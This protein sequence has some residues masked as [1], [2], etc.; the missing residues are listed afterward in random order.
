MYDFSAIS[1]F[2]GG[3]YWP[4]DGQLINDLRR[5]WAMLP[6]RRTSLLDACCTWFIERPDLQQVLREVGAVW[7]KISESLSGENQ[8]ALLRW[9]A[10]FD[11]SNW[12]KTIHN[13]QEV[14]QR[15]L[16]EELR[17]VEAERA[18]I[19]RQAALALPYQCSDLLEKRL[20]IEASAIDGIW[21]QL[22]NWP[23][24]AAKSSNP[25]QDELSSSLLDDRHSR[26]GL[27][28]VL[29]SLG[30]EWLDQDQA[31]RP[32]IEEEVRKLVADPPKI[33]A[34]SPDDTHEDG[35]GFL[36]RCAV[37]CWARYPD[38]ADWR[39]L[40]GSF[41]TAYR[42]RTIAQVFDEAFRVRKS[43]G[44][45]YG[46]LEA[47]ALEYAVVRRKADLHGFK[48]KPEMIH[49]W[50]Q[51]WLPKFAKGHG[52][53][54]TNEWSTVEFVE[55][56]PPP[57]NPHRGLTDGRTQR[58]SRRDYG[59]DMGV[60]L[61]AFG[62]LPP[63][64]DSR[65]AQERQHWLAIDNEI[66]AAYA[67][68]FPTDDHDDEE[69]EWEFQHWSADEKIYN[70][71][72]ARLFE[73]STTEQRE[74]WLPFLSLPPPAHHYITQ[75]LSVVLIET[76]RGASP[77]IAE[78]LP[79]WRAFAQHLFSLPRWTGRLRHRQEEVWK[80]IFFYG[81]PFDSVR[82]KDHAPLVKGMRDLFERHVRAMGSNSHEQSSL[83]GFVT[84]DAGK[85]L[86]P[87]ALEWLGPSWQHASS[88]FWSDVAESSSFENLLRY[89]WQNHFAEIRANAEMLKAFKTVT[90]NLAAHQVAVAIDIQ[91]QIGA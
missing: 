27:L 52:P 22:H 74:L 60:I 86:L 33:T 66:L 14:W 41:V 26:A 54:W 57:Y 46:E 48:A 72:A 71:I 25:D 34:Y 9:A 70:L 35:E 6:G 15:E 47:F 61:A 43:L 87:E 89:A 32:W 30:S 5:D 7:K 1:E 10:N 29:L 37:C 88:Y 77:R 75:F 73:C 67:R 40:V 58:F 23:F 36:A 79:I 59:L 56:F 18:H 4:Q 63:L 85:G 65:D 55:A 69:D 53:K 62:W 64:A 19:H 42:Y 90:L 24:T 2:L 80:Y 84:S 76:L 81:T 17:D 82:D 78:L 3:G 68:T 49:K 39:A 28:A 8:L 20:K 38:D 31:R 83:A 91:R 11:L 13:G 21:Q 45:H 50:L 16:P 44:K 12:K 51:T